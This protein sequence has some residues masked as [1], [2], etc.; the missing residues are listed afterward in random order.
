[1]TKPILAPA[2]YVQQVAL[3]VAGAEGAVPV[4]GAS[5]LPI[6]E[7]S[8]RGAVQ[9]VPDTNQEARRA[10]AITCTTAGSV[11][12]R[13]AD[14]SS[15]MLPISVGLSILPFA[16]KTVVTSGTTAVAAYS[17]LV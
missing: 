1:M 16:V 17:N 14:D 9:I 12:L 10:I 15:I 6:S 5:P 13:L 7:P 4:D 11:T 3:A 8:F 2:L